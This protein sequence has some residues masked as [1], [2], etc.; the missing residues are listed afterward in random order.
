MYARHTSPLPCRRCANAACA[1][2]YTSGERPA[3][4]CVDLLEE[5]EDGVGEGE[6]EWEGD[7][8]VPSPLPWEGDGT[9]RLRTGEEIREELL[10]EM[11]EVDA[12]VRGAA[13]C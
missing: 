2:V 5:V 6:D 12:S 4:A 10:N 9:W 3:C 13:A 8:P 7:P 1:D 11:R